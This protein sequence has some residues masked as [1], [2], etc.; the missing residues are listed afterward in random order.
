MSYLT[1]S[2]VETILS[3]ARL[4]EFTA[5]SGST[6]DASVLA[7]VRADVDDLIDSALAGRYAV[8]VT[9]ATDVRTI[10]P[11]AKILLKWALLVRRNLSPDEATRIAYEA[12][13][14]WLRDL[15][16]GDA[17]LSPSASPAPVP[18]TATG[19]GLAS[20]SIGSAE[21]VASGV[22]GLM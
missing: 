11:H 9:S 15:K 16:K 22:A 8:P 20:A 13:D 10:R 6:V 14:R 7:G 3:D 19:S 21:A 2:D 12:T 5:E 18:S 4:A 1:D 17:S